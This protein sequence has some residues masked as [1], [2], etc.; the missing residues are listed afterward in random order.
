M[1][2]WNIPKLYLGKTVLILGNGPSLPKLVTPKLLNKYPTI[3]VNDAGF[4]DGVDILFFGDAKWWRI[5]G[6]KMKGFCG[7]MV[8]Y[9][10]HPEGLG[11]ASY[12]SNILMVGHKSGSGI[13]PINSLIKFNRSSGAAAINL[14]YHLGAKQV[15]LLGFDMRQINGKKNWFDREWESDNTRNM[16]YEKFLQPFP[17]IA[18]DAECLGLDVVNATPNS[19]LTNFPSIE[20]GDL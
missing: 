13:C 14:A 6:H 1:R 5:R 9:N 16:S 11:G 10:R 8:T 19:A 20:V 3:G 7:L 2:F 12:P 15:V 18:Y 4:L 17:Q